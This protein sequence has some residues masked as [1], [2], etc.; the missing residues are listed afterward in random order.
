MSLVEHYE[1]PTVNVSLPG[2]VWLARCAARVA[3]RDST[4]ETPRYRQIA[5]EGITPKE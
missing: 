2:E 4:R 1:H 3:L 5:L